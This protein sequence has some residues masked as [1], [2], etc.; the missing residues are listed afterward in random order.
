MSIF[1]LASVLDQ[2][3]ELDVNGTVYTLET[4]GT[5]Y[6][7]QPLSLV[8]VSG[9]TTTYQVQVTFEATNFRTRNLAIADLY[10]GDFVVCTTLQWDF[11]SSQKQRHVDS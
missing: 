4:N 5:G 1:G 11:L 7:T 3:V 6:A 9:H 10:G 2:L 8:A